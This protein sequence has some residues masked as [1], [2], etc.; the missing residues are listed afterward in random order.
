MRYSLLIL[1][2]LLSGCDDKILTPVGQEYLLTKPDFPLEISLGFNPDGRFYGKA[3]ND[4]WGQYHLYDH[5]I[6][7]SGI[8]NTMKTDILP[9]MKAEREFFDALTNG[10]S[11]E[12][13][14]EG[15]KIFYDENGILEFKIKKESVPTPLSH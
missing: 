1:F 8:T 5:V 10:H 4:Y 7:F 12:I 15:L 2:I 14:K 6:S 3:I 11:F 9:R 13:K